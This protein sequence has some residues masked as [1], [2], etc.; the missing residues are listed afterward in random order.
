MVL[1]QRSDVVLEDKLEQ[2]SD[3]VLGEDKVTWP[4]TTRWCN[5]EVL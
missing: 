4:W 2:R 3:M 5:D 1:V